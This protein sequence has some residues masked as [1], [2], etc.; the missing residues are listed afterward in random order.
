MV[1]LNI[2]STTTPTTAAAETSHRTPSKCVSDGRNS[3][4]LFLLP[5]LLVLLSAHTRFVLSV[6]TVAAS[7]ST[8]NPLLLAAGM[9]A[10]VV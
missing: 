2:E 4:F 5:F 8:I 6:Q 10:V 9:E 7:N 1:L 3:D